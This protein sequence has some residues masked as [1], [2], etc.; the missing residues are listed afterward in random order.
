VSDEWVCKDLE[1]YIN[2]MVSTIKDLCEENKRLGKQLESLKQQVTAN[3][4][5]SERNHREAEQ[6]LFGAKDDLHDLKQALQKIAE[7]RKE[8]ESQPDIDFEAVERIIR[9][10]ERKGWIESHDTTKPAFT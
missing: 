8:P 4:Q 9:I 6:G 7:I 5:L 10:A 2:E 1:H 3:H